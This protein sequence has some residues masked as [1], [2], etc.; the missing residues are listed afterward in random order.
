[1]ISSAGSQLAAERLGDR[2]RGDVVFAVTELESQSPPGEPRSA[3]SGAGERDSW[4]VVDGCEVVSSMRALRTSSDRGATANEVV[5]RS[6]R[7]P[8]CRALTLEKGHRR[9]GRR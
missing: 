5:Y 7:L 3:W 2:V 1:M 9:S 4:L 6:Y 8:A